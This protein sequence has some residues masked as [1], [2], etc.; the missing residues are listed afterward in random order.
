MCC[1]VPLGIGVHVLKYYNK[2]GIHVLVC[3]CTVNNYPSENRLGN[4][5]G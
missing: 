3:W 5:T 1:E 2:P 4:Q